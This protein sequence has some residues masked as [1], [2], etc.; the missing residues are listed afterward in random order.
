MSTVYA[1]CRLN[2]A[3]IRGEDIATITIMFIT[4]KE[5]GKEAQNER[6]TI[7]ERLK[8]FK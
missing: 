1:V 5:R 4:K 6:K 7:N 8:N 2:A 3:S